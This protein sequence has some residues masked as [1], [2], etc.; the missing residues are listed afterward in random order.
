MVVEATHILYGILTTGVDNDAVAPFITNT[1]PISEPPVD[2]RYPNQNVSRSPI[3][4]ANFS[5]SIDATSVANATGT[6]I[7]RSIILERLSGQN[8]S[9]DLTIPNDQLEVYFSRW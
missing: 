9:V 3:L 5:E 1:Y 6:A 2:P 4:E 8:G 7:D